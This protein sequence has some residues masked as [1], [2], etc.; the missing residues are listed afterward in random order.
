MAA[1]RQLG[2]DPGGDAT[3]SDGDEVAVEDADV[4][5]VVLVDVVA[6]EVDEPDDVLTREMNVTA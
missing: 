5:V 3:G 6:V 1:E 2:V 4:V